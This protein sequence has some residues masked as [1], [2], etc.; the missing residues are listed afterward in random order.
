MVP[1]QSSRNG[2]FPQ[3]Q[4]SLPHYPLDPQ[5]ATLSIRLKS[6]GWESQRSP[7]VPLLNQL[8]KSLLNDVKHPL[9]C[10]SSAESSLGSLVQRCLVLGKHWH[11]LS[12]VQ[13]SNRAGHCLARTFFLEAHIL[14][15]ASPFKMADQYTS[16]VI[17]LYRNKSCCC[18]F[19]LFFFLNV[20]SCLELEYCVTV[21]CDI[22]L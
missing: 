20:I 6:S 18:F 4:P 9:P 1:I 19:S 8:E 3:L 11:L 15:S 17:L 16:K 5:N 12:T 2:I 10:P 14:I 22:T 13:R 21:V 7:S